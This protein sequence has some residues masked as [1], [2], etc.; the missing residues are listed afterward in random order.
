MYQTEA[1]QWCR[2]A[3]AALVTVLC[4]GAV[5]CGSSGGHQNDRPAAQADGV[6]GPLSKARLTA[7]SFTDGEKVGAFIASEYDLDSPFGDEYSARPADCLPFVSLK[8]G[9]RRYGAPVAEVN[10]EVYRPDEPLQENTA[11]QLRSYAH[12]DAAR[13]MKALGRAA[14]ACRDGFTEDR[15]VAEAHYLDARALTAPRTGDEA[16]AFRFTVR[17]AGGEQKHYEYLTVVRSGS[18]TLSF[19]TEI[20]SPEDVGG[21]PGSVIEDQWKKFRAATK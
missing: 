1:R 21:V 12:G 5:A 9:T 7:A 14:T 6:P 13:V 8:K 15:S 19:R 11:V 18:T 3:A 2:A 20:D 10:R 17:D 16:A 4:A